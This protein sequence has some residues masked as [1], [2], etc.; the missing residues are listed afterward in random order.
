MNPINIKEL[1]KALNLSTS[2]VSRAFRNNSDI[3]KE[4]KERILAMAKELHY[5]PNL[6]ASNLRERKSKTIA[7]IVPELANNFFLQAINGLEQVASQKGYHILIYLTGDDYD[8]EISFINLL[9]NGRA[10]GIIMSVSGE[11]AKEH[12]YLHKL[13]TKHIPLVFFDRIYEDIEAASVTTNDYESSFAAT[14]HLILTGCKKIAFLVINKNLSIGKTRLQGY[15][16]A[17]TQYK[18]PYQHELVIDC[19]NNNEENAELLKHIFTELKPDGVFASVERLAI[20]TYY[21][22]Q[23]LNISI[24]GK[25]KV[26]CFSSLEISSLLNPSLTTITQPAFAMGTQAANLLFKALEDATDFNPHEHIV[27]QSELII[28]KSTST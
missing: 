9:H 27:L 14:E 4:T 24:P 11:A 22:C 13:K 8:K 18:I 26:I 10:D 7:V 28:R 5:E 6:Y 16:D 20:S 2:T 3:N 25:L 23:E 15:V 1:A 17:L 12:S 19:S 21:V